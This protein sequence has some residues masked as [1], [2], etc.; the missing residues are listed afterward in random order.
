VANTKDPGRLEPTPA[1][2]FEHVAKSGDAFIAALEAATTTARAER[3]RLAAEI[4]D[5]QAKR[6]EE[7]RLFDEIQSLSHLEFLK[8]CIDA[9]MDKHTIEELRAKIAAITEEQR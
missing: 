3:T 4:T 1:S 5:L 8:R 9:G 7:Q 2:A 6:A